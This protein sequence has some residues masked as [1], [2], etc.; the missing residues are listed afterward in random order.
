MV[1]RAGH[2]PLYAFYSAEEALRFWEHSGTLA[3]LSSLEHN[4]VLNGSWKFC[5]VPEP[6]MVPQNF[7]AAD[8]EDK[9]WDDIEVPSNWQCKGY[10]QPIYTNFQYPFP[11]NLPRARRS[12]AS[13]M[14]SC[15]Q[16]TNRTHSNPTGCYRIAF[17][18]SEKWLSNDR[19]VFIN[20]DGVD[21][22]FHC[23]LNGNFIGYSV[24]SRLPAEFEIT[25]SIKSGIN[26]LTLQV[27]RWSSGSYLEDQDQWWLSG[28]YRD[29]RIYSKPACFIS[30]YR[31][32]TSNITTNAASLSVE[33]KL[34]S[35][36]K[37][38]KTE[39]GNMQLLLLDNKGVTVCETRANINPNPIE[40]KVHDYGNEAARCEYEYSSTLNCDILCPKLWSAETPILYTAILC[41]MTKEGEELDCEACRVGFRTVE[42]CNGMLTVNGIPVIIQGV[43]RHE[44]CPE[45]GKY[46]SEELMVKDICLMKQNNFNAVRTAH[47][48]NHPRF[49]D[50]CDE[51][52][53]FVVDEANIETHGFQSL[54]HST[55]LLSDLHVW[56]NAFLSR[57]TRM[58]E[59][60]FN[61]ACVI[62]W[63]LGNESGLGRSHRD[64]V[65]WVKQ[66]DKSRPIMYEGGGAR[67]SCTDIVC[68]MYARI[69]VCYEMLKAKVETR[70]LILCEYSHAMGNSNGGLDKYWKHFREPNNLQGGFIWDLI[71][72]GIS[73]YDDNGTKFWAYG[74]DF[75]DIPND[76]QF[77]ING[78]TFP[79]R[80]VHPAMYEAKFL[81]QPI[82]V[83]WLMPGQYQTV[84]VSNWYHFLSLTDLE[85]TLY[86]YTYDSTELFHFPVHLTVPPGGT[87]QFDL[88]KLLQLSTSYRLDALK[89]VALVNFIT[90]TKH[91]TKW[92]V[93]GFEL[94]KSQLV[95]PKFFCLNDYNI[96][97]DTTCDVRIRQ[98]GCFIAVT[99]GEL[100]CYF[101]TQGEFAGR[102]HSVS[103]HQTPFIHGT[104]EPCFWRAC[105]DNDRG[106]D[107][108]S[109][110]E[111]WIDI[112][113]DQLE[114]MSPHFFVERASGYCRVISNFSL[115]PKNTNSKSKPLVEVRMIY[116][117]SAVDTMSLD[118]KLN[119]VR[120]IPEIPRIGLALKCDARLEKV[121]W[122]GRGPH[123]CYQDRKASALFGR[124]SSTVDALHTPYIV[125][126][127]NGGR[128]D[129]KWVCLKDDVGR[130]VRF[131]AETP[132]FF[133]QFSASNFDLDSLHRAKHTN[134]L[135]ESGYTNVHLDVFH[136]GVGGDDS[137]SPSVHEEF[138]TKSREWDF[139]TAI[140]FK[141]S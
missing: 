69:E 83:T 127:E 14:G 6:D 43:N 77:C 76:K 37:S 103:F 95:F 139:R 16:I 141:S 44:H 2:C 117:F 104:I 51:Y 60:D 10:D 46:V 41:L 11:V 61:H 115:V 87:R 33:I 3:E 9:H 19:R 47:Y 97:S 88:A 58:V 101:S 21:S 30:D 65:T 53:M 8:F 122:L 131:H 31:V 70:P 27:M 20:F 137:W 138:L 74:G 12:S 108:L 114:T 85:T 96:L 45:N 56:R 84:K 107:A 5:L 128:A 109:F 29:V 72:Q 78:L 140:V 82:T 81:Q 54:L 75:G 36:K 32:F 129:V 71:D 55:G 100:E 23:W 106:G 105:T 89:S 112:G 121:E 28:V 15:S 116:T 26:V 59:R 132:T 136:M 118:V 99:N 25:A 52:G 1:C 80:Q 68:P 62:V 13:E 17:Q 35:K 130:C 86:A 90:R 135:Q 64:M 92:C 57:F 38:L 73:K 79:D 67:S 120:A 34:N 93:R 39:L 110:A 124:Y 22:A 49:Y 119:F 91:D 134:E 125:P 102:V 113:F 42:I 40:G 63:S 94:A 66:K 98:E 126:S 111:R 4:L 133:S 24:D 123:E 7:Q 18:S 50:L 48:P